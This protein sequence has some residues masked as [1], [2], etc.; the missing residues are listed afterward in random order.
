MK[1]IAILGTRGYPYV[2]SGYETFV[3]RVAPGLA[4]LGYEVTVYC[5]RGL[6]ADRPKEVNGVRLAY[7]PAIEHK[8]LSQFSHSFLST[9]HALDAGHRTLLYVNTA[10]G[11]FAWLAG[12]LG[13]KTIMNVDGVEWL[14]PKWRG[15]GA[16]YFYWAS[17]VSA[18]HCTA[19]VAD[20]DAMKAIYEKEFHRSSTVIAYGAE[21]MKSSDPGVLRQF[22]LTA[23]DYYLIV[24]RL[25][26][27]NNADLIVREFLASTCGRKLVVVGD[28][29][30]DDHYARSVKSMANERVV[31]TGYIRD[32]QLLSE[33][34][35]GSYAYLHGHEF[36]GTN[37][38]LLKAMASGCAIIALDTPFSREVLNGDRHG[39]YF[40]KTPENL[41]TLLGSIEDSPNLLSNLREG[42]L[43]RVTSVYNWDR[44]IHGYA[45]LIERV[46]KVAS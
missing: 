13:R 26:P 9:L 45:D 12:M 18:R 6:F 28:V 17:R 11:P 31:F 34:Y 42:M 7:V 25:I 36:G 21:A 46:S 32:A 4:N 10:N 33:L 30:Y 38:T 24:G 35:C 40:T 16:R 27:D 14:R 22:G 41:S 43:E 39:I 19:L 3:S 5:H 2:Y 44:V 29:P 8:V 20:A 37:P 1:R 23:S 15:L